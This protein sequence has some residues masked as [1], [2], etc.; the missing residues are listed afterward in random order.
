MEVF[1]KEIVIDG[2]LGKTKY[3]AI[4]IEFQVR[5]LPHVHCFL[6]IWNAPIL[7]ESPV[8]EYLSFIDNIVH[9]D[10][11]SKNTDPELHELMRFYQLHR[12]SITCHK[13]KNEACRFQCGKL[14]SK[15]RIVVKPL[16]SNLPENVKHL[17]LIKRK[18][19]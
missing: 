16:L 8:D 3:Y 2:S 14:F 7:T 10:L 19:F 11:P 5:G 6:W 18:G 15:Q 12:H 4:R 13:Y 9:A 17:V 1:L